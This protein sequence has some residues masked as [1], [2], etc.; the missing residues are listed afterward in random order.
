MKPIQTP[1]APA[2]IGPYSQ[3]IDSGAGLVFFSGQL[4]IDLATG[5]F[6]EGCVINLH[7]PLWRRR[8]LRLLR[9]R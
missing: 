6:P 3:A 9:H 8:S 2:A 7:K 5:A 1:K 4:P